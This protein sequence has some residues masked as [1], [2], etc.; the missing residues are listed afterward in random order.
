MCNFIYLGTV[1]I[2]MDQL[3]YAVKHPESEYIDLTKGE[4]EFRD[5]VNISLGFIGKETPVEYRFNK[6]DADTLFEGLR[7]YA[8]SLKNVNLSEPQ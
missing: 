4:T 7:R 5:V 6:E 2:N 8:K 1:V 3:Q